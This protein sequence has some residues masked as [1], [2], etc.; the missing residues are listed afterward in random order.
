MIRLLGDLYCPVGVHICAEMW[1]SRVPVARRAT[2]E[3]HA[4]VPQILGAAAA[5]HSGFVHAS[6]GVC[7]S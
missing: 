2:G 7:G 5:R 1:E 6:C 3:L 4:E